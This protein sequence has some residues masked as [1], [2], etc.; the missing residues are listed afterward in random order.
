MSA[1]ERGAEQALFE[2]ARPARILNF[3]RVAE[4]LHLRP[5]EAYICP[6]CR[7]TKGQAWECGE[8]EFFE[9]TCQ[10]CGQGYGV[11]LLEVEA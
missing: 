4:V 11:S 3:D 2:G 7:A 8:P 6:H 5:D 1:A 9:M 10:A